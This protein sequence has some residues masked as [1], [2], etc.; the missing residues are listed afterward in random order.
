M[1]SEKPD[2][3]AVELCE[4]RKNALVDEKKWDETEITD[5]IKS[6]RTSL[7]LTQLFLSNFQRKLGD[8]VGV[9]PGAEMLEAV[10]MAQERGIRVELVDRDIKVT[11][12]RAQRRLGFFE[13]MKLFYGLL[14]DVLGGV[15]ITEETIEALKKKDMIT[16]L[17]D[18]L[19]REVPT[20]KET[21]VD[22]R[23]RYIAYRILTLEGKKI[24][25]V[26]GAG[27]VNGI[28]KILMQVKDRSG[29]DEKVSALNAVDERKSKILYLG[30]I[31]TALFGLIL[32]WGFLKH[33][34]GFTLSLF[35]KWFLIHG[36]LSAI[37]A[38]IAFGHPLTILTAFL[39]APFTSLNPTIAAGWFAGAMELRMRKPRV[40]DFK[41]LFKLN[42]VRD[43][44]GNR[45]TRIFLVI[46]F[47]NL[48]SSIG[49]FI[50]LPYLAALI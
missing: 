42:S 30:Y 38:A 40:A 32:I 24:V 18:E 13:K 1:D 47:A 37:G 36:I 31:M 16:E 50:A 8:E 22:E 28:A 46:V 5:V 48:G 6:G 10:R 15:K 7:F 3:V 35:L 25:G 17:L 23:D 44:W 45:V 29:L 49:T 4:Q 9:K 33:D 21:L 12:N 19:S 34:I 43:Y 2:V 11:L 27:H 41:E 14:E 20:L 39:V 26:V